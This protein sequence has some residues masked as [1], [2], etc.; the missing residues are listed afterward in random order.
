MAKHLLRL[1]SLCLILGLVAFYVFNQPK[2]SA[3]AEQAAAAYSAGDY[4]KAL[5]LF[6]QFA[7]TAEVRA[8]KDLRNAVYSR[9]VEIESRLALATSPVTSPVHTPTQIDAALAKST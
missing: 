8:N 6:K 5:P 4:A 7:A 1:V 9:I 2:Q 3:L